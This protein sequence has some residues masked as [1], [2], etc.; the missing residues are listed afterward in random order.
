MFEQKREN[1]H[2]V[3][4]ARIDKYEG[5]IVL[6]INIHNARVQYTFMLICF[7]SLLDYMLHLH[8]AC[9]QIKKNSTPH[10]GR[11]E[12]NSITARALAKVLW[13]NTSL[14]NL[15]LSR[16]GIDDQA[17]AYMAR[18]LKRNTALKTI[19]LGSNE[20]G[21]VACR[22]FGD[23]LCSNSTL[24][25]LNLESNHLTCH[26]TNMSG[27][28]VLADMFRKN[29]TLTSIN[30]WRCALGEEAGEALSQGIESNQS[31]TF[32]ELG[33]NSLSMVDE[34]SIKTA[35][36]M[37]FKRFE[38]LQMRRKNEQE[39]V[40]IIS[41]KEKALQ[42]QLR[43]ERQLRE[44]YMEQKQLRAEERREKEEKRLQLNTHHTLF[45][46]CFPNP[47]CARVSK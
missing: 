9:L 2:P 8:P 17:G 6:S 13:T 46:Y 42:D 10:S 33:H 38:E 14:T 25:S 11:I 1:N 4:S 24:R 36:D 18:L 7:S 28:R 16:N 27:L 30:M 20:L 12:A 43:V 31:I 32:L 22:A 19:C 21:P 37:N 5:K 26:G 44:W 41:A 15:D 45:L 47:L 23:A 3:R 40:D 34:H 39:M 29:K 35:L